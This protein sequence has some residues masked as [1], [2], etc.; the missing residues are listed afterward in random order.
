MRKL[1]F[2]NI[3]V[4]I[5][6]KENKDTLYTFDYRKMGRRNPTRVWRSIWQD[7]NTFGFLGD[8]PPRVTSYV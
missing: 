5:I 7:Q 2:K 3:L 1:L 4:H 6:S 8:K